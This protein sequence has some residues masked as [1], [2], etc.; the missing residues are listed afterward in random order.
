LSQARVTGRNGSVLTV[1]VG[2]GNTNALLISQ[3]HKAG[4]STAGTIIGQCP[5]VGVSGE[6]WPCQ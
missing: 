6:V 4:Y 1:E 3:L 2:P 5:S